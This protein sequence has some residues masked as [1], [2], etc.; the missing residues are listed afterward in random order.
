MKQGYQKVLLVA[1]AL[2]TSLFSATQASAATRMLA[3]APYDTDHRIHAKILRE[4]TTLGAKLS[5]FTK[6]FAKKNG[7]T[8][9][10]V[11]DIGSTRKGR[12]L[13]VTIVDAVSRGNAFTGH[14]KYV[15][16]EG[17]LWENGKLVGR[18][19]GQRSSMG[20]FAAGY[21]GSCSVLGRCVKA[22]GKDIANW[23]L[24]PSAARRIGE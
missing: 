1:L 5:K 8:I 20:G 9:D 24:D 6:S 22:L 23:L 21:K 15:R 7:I 17:S 11:D 10:L 18:F 12:S 3:S 13:R 2:S 19:D 4:C 14:S 16:I